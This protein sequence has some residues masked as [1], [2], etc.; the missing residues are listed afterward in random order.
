MST[1]I[2][3]DSHAGGLRFQ[4]LLDPAGHGEIDQE[5]EGIGVPNRLGTQGWVSGP[6]L[7]VTLDSGLRRP[8]GRAP[9]GGRRTAACR[10]EDT[11]LGARRRITVMTRSAIATGV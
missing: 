11:G 3:R 1:L 8:L 6:A 5:A 7:V 9:R 2:D 10:A 4:A